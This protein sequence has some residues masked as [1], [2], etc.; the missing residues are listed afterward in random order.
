[1]AHSHPCEREHSCVSTLDESAGKVSA[2]PETNPEKTAILLGNLNCGKTT[3]FNYLCHKHRNVSNFP[4]TSVEIGR[5][6][7]SLGSEKYHLIDT[8]GIDNLLPSS[9]HEKISLEILLRERPDIIALIADGKNLRKALLL[10]L[11]LTEFNIPLTIDINMMDEMRQRGIR[12]N[13]KKLSGLLGVPVTKTIASEG[14]GASTFCKTLRQPKQSCITVSYPAK[15]ESA[16]SIVSK[17]LKDFNL[18][19]RAVGAALLSGNE[20]MK[21]YI[22]EKCGSTPAE[23]VEEIVLDVQSMFNRPLSVVMSEARLKVVDQI[24]AEVQVVSPPSRALLSEKIGKWSREPLTGIP[25]ALMVVVLMYL[26][27]GKFGAQTLVGIFEGG[28][29][30]GWLTPLA[31]KLLSGI[32]SELVTDL[33]VGRFGLLSVG[34]TL[35]FGIVVP[36]LLSFFFAFGILEDSGYLPRLSVL[37]DRTLQKVGLSGR[38]VLPLVMGFSCVTMAILTTRVLESK[39]ERFI[40]SCLLILGI[41]CA[42]VMAVMLVMLEGMSIWAT[43]TVFGLIATQIVVAGVILGRI[44]PGCGSDFILE[45]PPIRLPRLRNLIRNTGRR[46]WWFIEE[47]V[48]LFLLA[49]FIL[50]VLDQVGMLVV[51]ERVAEPV[52]TGFLGLPAESAELAIMKIIRKESAG[53]H[54]SQLHAAGVFDNIQGVVSL[55]L[56]TFLF[57]CLNSIL[58]LIRE[59][60][61]KTTLLMIAC[62]ASYALMLGATVNWICRTFNITFS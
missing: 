9:E 20:E 39:R 58:V 26:F 59:R 24:L 62:V 56:L 45:L 3:I 42:P 14:V 50:F 33:F 6:S 19:E 10:T 22:A 57:P 30:G 11:A 7:L 34:L 5:G 43:V 47:A 48:P 28:L 27:V 13:A 21:R 29:F 17:L 53:A 40:A 51:I 15:I 46:V 18:S 25:I 12:V 54:L 61:A 41:P 8:P 37:L 49:T 32:N 1:M 52:L 36:V 60:G 31:E 4:G 23:Q 55:L 2:P 44:M 16:I 38:C 35:A